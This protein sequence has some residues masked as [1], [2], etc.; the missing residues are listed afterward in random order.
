MSDLYYSFH[1]SKGSRPLNFEDFE[2]GK[3]EGPVQIAIRAIHAAIKPRKKVELRAAV[4]NLSNHTVQLT[5]DFGLAIKHGEEVHEY[6]GGPRSS[7]PI[8]LEPG[9]FQ[10]IL[11]WRLD[12]ESDLDFAIN[13][14]WVIY[15]PKGGEDVIS[16]IMTIE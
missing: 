8:Y 7:V 16:K 3:A 10:E 5:N 2:W 9:E 15:R 1:S 4:R 13:E 11:A 12:K 14:Y 6:F